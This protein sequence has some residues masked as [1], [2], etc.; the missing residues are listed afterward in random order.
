M[1]TIDKILLGCAGFLLAFTITIIIIFCIFQT[2][3]DTLVSSVFGLFSCEA[4]ITLV[5][6]AIKR[7]QNTKRK[8][9]K[10]EK[11]DK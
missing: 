9:D 7:H 11:T 3:P 5:I 8:E 6:W 4:F 10:N 1:N 2:I